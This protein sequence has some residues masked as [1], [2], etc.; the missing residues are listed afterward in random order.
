MIY[1]EAFMEAMRVLYNHYG[2]SQ[3]DMPY[4]KFLGMSG[5]TKESVIDMLKIGEENGYSIE[6]QLKL[7][8]WLLGEAK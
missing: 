1:E 4:D 7:G 6:A 8:E 5:Q 2:L 3:D